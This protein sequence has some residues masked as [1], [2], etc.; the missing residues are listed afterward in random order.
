[1]QLEEYLDPDA[2]VAHHRA[3]ARRIAELSAAGG[4]ARPALAVWPEYVATFLVL[5]GR[6]KEIAGCTTT[7]QA[8]RRIVTRHPLR[9][10]AVMAR[11]R[12]RRL[13]PAVL[14]MLAPHAHDLYVETFGDIARH[15]GM[16]VVAGSGLYPRPRGAEGERPF[17]A[18]SAS[19]YNTSY[20]FAPDGSVAAVTRKVN[21][22]PTQEDVLGLRAG[23]PGDLG[24]LDTALGRLST[25]ICYDGFHEP[26]TS[27]EPHFVRGAAL[28]DALG[29]EIVAQPSANAWAWD[30][31]WAFNDAGESQLRSEQWFA[32]GMA[33]EMQELR[34]VRFVVNPQLVGD[35]LDSHFEAPSL[36]L[37]RKDGHVAVLARAAS[38]CDEEVLHAR[39]ARSPAPLGAGGSAED[40]GR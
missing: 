18:R 7:D 31:P 9:L 6:R 39:V 20:T 38:V 15:L 19:V 17:V 22:V 36:I 27:T 37:E 13:A 4:T 25:L 3:L 21:L 2:F 34:S 32:E 8:L 10:A 12:T 35:V 5:L 14:T 23:A 1:M 11:H 24:V 28:V 29:A 16:W 33:R 40:G 30:A 26:H